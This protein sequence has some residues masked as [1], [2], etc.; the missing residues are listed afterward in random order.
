M[1]HIMS[2]FV[3]IRCDSFNPYILRISSMALKQSYD[4][5][6]TSKAILKNMGQ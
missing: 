2:G 3:V 1:V 6:N 5:P 4:C